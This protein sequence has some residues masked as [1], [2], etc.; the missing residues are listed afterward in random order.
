MP[1]DINELQ[2]EWR[3]IVLSKLNNLET[4]HNDLRKDIADIKDSFTQIKEFQDLRNKVEK[5]EEFKSKAIGIILGSNVFLV[6][7]GWI[8][9]TFIHK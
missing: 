3:A 8:I 1:D 2:K 9:Q 6:F 7:I 4:S 5:L